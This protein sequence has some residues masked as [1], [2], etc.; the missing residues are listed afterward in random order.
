M[1]ST[2]PSETQY[3][4]I[5]ALATTLMLRLLPLPHNHRSPCVDGIRDQ[6]A[7][8]NVED[9]THKKPSKTRSQIYPIRSMALQSGSPSVP[10]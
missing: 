4:L 7:P 6:E 10:P 5:P 1:L 8:K 3:D 2:L 9:T